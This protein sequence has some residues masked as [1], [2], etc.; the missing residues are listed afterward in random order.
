MDGTALKI[1]VDPGGGVCLTGVPPECA[2]NT[3][4]RQLILMRV[5]WSFMD[6]LLFPAGCQ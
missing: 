4:I 6:Q 3:E 5:V 2:T 1:Q